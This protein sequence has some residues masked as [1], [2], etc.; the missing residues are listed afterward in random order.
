MSLDIEQA[1]HPAP[2]QPPA[3]PPDTVKT[4]KPSDHWTTWLR[5]GLRATFG[6]RLDALPPAIQPAWLLCLFLVIS[7]LDVGVSRMDFEDSAVVFSPSGW[8]YGWAGTGIWLTVLGWCFLVAKKD[9]RHES[10]VLAWVTLEWVSIGVLTLAGAALS[11]FERDPHSPAWLLSTEV[12][13]GI[14]GGFVL[15]AAVAQWRIAQ[16][17]VNSRVAMAAL[18]LSVSATNV[19]TSLW[20]PGVSW[21][22]DHAGAPRK[23]Q[24][25][26]SQSAFEQQQALF[27]AQTEALLPSTGA[28]P[29]VYGLVYAPYE[30]D[31]FLRESRLVSGVL[32][33]RFGAQGR[34]MTL[35]NHTSTT[36]TTPWA[37]PGNL[38]RALKSIGEKMNPAQDVLVL[39]L[40]SHGGSDHQLASAHWP[41]SVPALTAAEMRSMLDSAGIR[42]AAVLIS[43]CYAG[44][45][46]DPLKSDSSLIMTAADKDH[47]SYGCGARSELTFFGR[48]LFDEELRQT[49]SF[50]QAFA[51]AV[52]RIRQR[53]EEAGK[54]DGFSNPQLA[55]GPGFRQHWTHV[56]QPALDAAP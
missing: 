24:L 34:T 40:T 52:P 33:S 23:P 1:A 13:W 22:Y 21:A 46:I 37:T 2:A 56:V 55:V 26:L 42:Y 44:G 19:L 9:R 10:P 3:Q 49:R 29:Q 16:A 36:A 14:W 47:T 18:V 48:A 20:L 53:E 50:E 51:N 54:D 17:L 39:Y 38:E 27:Q 8:L 12:Q 41:L 7:A 32:T 31:V 6:L 25:V 5:Q 30:A 15:W 43:A 4:P 28:G 35:L 11:A 45:W